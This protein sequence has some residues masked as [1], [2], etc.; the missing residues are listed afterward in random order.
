MFRKSREGVI[1]LT[2]DNR[3]GSLK[4]VAY[5]KTKI[6]IYGGLASIGGNCVVVESSSQKVM[7][8]QGVNFPR[9]KEFY[10]ISIQPDSVEELRELGVLPP[11]EAY[12]DVDQICITHL[13][14]D[15]LGSLNIP[16]EPSVYLPSKEIAETLSRAWW[17][18]WR[19]HLLP[20]TQLFIKFMDLDECKNVKIA[21]VSH[22]AF[23]AYALRINADDAVVVYTGDLRITP[24]YPSISDTLSSLEKIGEEG[25]DIL[26]I[27]GTNF[28]RRL[29]Y[30]PAV[31]YITTI[32]ELLKDYEKQVLFISTH[33]L[34]LEAIL[35]TLETLLKFG[36]T[37]AFESPYYAQLLDKMLEY[38]D[39]R[40]EYELFFTPRS[41]KI[42]HLNNFE[43]AFLEELRDRKLAI[44]LSPYGIKDLKY[45]LNVLNLP[46]E[47]C[48]HITVIGEPLS[49][50][51]IIE[52]RK[53]ESWLKLL[54]I[55]SL[56]IHVSGHYL[57]HEFKKIINTLKP[58]ELIPI[59]TQAPSAM[60]K[61]FE[62][63]KGSKISDIIT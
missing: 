62:K 47:G 43:I 32:K 31:Q 28:G 42:V 37:P 30:L 52:E 50:E 23:P 53:L 34:D 19:Q 6:R 25:V 48:L 56:R 16:N 49:E 7:L 63:Y 60:I 61:L 5:G 15:H 35:S 27:E 36:Y 22:S 55:T 45:L 38:G 10:G 4:E 8:D 13:H 3:Q 33:P 1:S 41:S 20:K 26:I 24:L 44:F 14:L 51:S 18:G 58:K 12:E 11:R 39:I 54:G 21:K 40:L 17:F 2:S 46:K 59:H 9:L 57:P 29:N